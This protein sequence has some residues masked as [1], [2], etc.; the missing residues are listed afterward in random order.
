[1]KHD[2]CLA[3]GESSTCDLRIRWT[4]RRVCGLSR[5]QFDQR[6]QAGSRSFR[7][8]DSRKSRCLEVQRNGGESDSKLRQVF[9]KQRWR[10]LSSPHAEVSDSRANEPR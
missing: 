8:M 9:L 7:A 4:S 3:A 6:A 2:R 5:S 1:M 10:E